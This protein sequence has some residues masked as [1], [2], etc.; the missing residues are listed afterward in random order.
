MVEL[1]PSIELLLE[2]L[3]LLST[4][5]SVTAD[6]VDAVEV[7]LHRGSSSAV[8]AFAIGEDRGKGRVEVIEN[9]CNING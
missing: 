2:L 9:Q 1:L 5:V 3:T 7:K 4:M 8:V 6:P